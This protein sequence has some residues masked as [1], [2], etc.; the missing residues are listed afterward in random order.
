MAGAPWLPRGQNPQFQHKGVICSVTS[1]AALTSVFCGTGKKSRGESGGLLLLIFCPSR[2]LDPEK[3][4]RQTAPNKQGLWVFGNVTEKAKLRQQKSN[5]VLLRP[6][7]GS[8][9]SNQ[10]SLEQR[11]FS[12]NRWT[13]KS[14]KSRCVYQ[15]GRCLVWEQ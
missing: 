6:S 12:K 14:D 3:E 15:R 9:T 4:E 11:G 2:L 10:Q 1:P 13:P 7:R 5:A 8:E